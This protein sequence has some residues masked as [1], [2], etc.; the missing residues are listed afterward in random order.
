MN[1][2]WTN[3]QKKNHR[4]TQEIQLTIINVHTT[5]A[6][7]DFLSWVK[8]NLCHHHNPRKLPSPQLI[9]GLGDQF[10]NHY[11]NMIWKGS[12]HCLFGICDSKTCM[13]NIFPRS[14]NMSLGF[15]SLENYDLCLLG[16]WHNTTF[17]LLSNI[18]SSQKT[19]TQYALK[20]QMT[21]LTFS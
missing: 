9:F 11:I 17:Q 21:Y 6:K 10:I 4:L 7:I 18:T 19:P 5:K 1:P 16:S 2:N 3:Q 20:M 14:N 12:I 8:K 13:I 15:D